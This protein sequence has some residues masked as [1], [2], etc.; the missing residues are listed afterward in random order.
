V[1]LTLAV[2]IMMSAWIIRA[3]RRRWSTPNV[4]LPTPN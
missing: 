4:Q 1:I 2:I 3:V